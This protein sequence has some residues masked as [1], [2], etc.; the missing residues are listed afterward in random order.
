MPMMSPPCTNITNL[1]VGATKVKG[2]MG[3]RERL[4]KSDLFNPTKVKD[5][6]EISKIHNMSQ[7]SSMSTVGNPS[8]G[9]G[10]CAKSHNA[11]LFINIGLLH[12]G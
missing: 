10:A 7:Y 1:D 9:Y 5:P 8:H 6:C 11:L 3:G 12:L 4:C 2:C